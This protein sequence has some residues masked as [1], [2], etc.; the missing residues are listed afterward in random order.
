MSW[1]ARFLG[2]L[3]WAL[4]TNN[5]HAGLFGPS[6]PAECYQKY[7]PKVR[8]PDAL[9]VLRFA[10]Q[11]GYGG[12]DI[13]PDAVKVGRCISGE[14]G[15]MYSYESTKKIINKCTRDLPQAFS[16]FDSE[17]MA[18]VNDAAEEAARIQ[19]FNQRRTEDAIRD[20]QNGSVSIFDATTGTYKN[21][22]KTGNQLNCF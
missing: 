6:D 21:C 15:V 14:A 18:N 22:I 4:L 1:T 3:I 5:A 13:N 12:G 11:V 16:V 8:L 2:I 20:S 7:A 19:R 9:N 10:C 17:L